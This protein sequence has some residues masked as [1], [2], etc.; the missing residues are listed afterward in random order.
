MLKGKIFGYIDNN[1]KWIYNY[2]MKLEIK[3]FSLNYFGHSDSLHSINHTFYEGLNVVF[4]VEGSGKTSLLK[5]IAGVNYHHDG[6]VLFEDKPVTLGKECDIS[7]V[8]DDLGFFEKRSL[9]YNLMYP[10]IIR[11]KP[12]VEAMEIIKKWLDEF[13]IP[14]ILLESKVFRLAP[15]F[16]VSAGLIRGFYRESKIIILDNP[17]ASLYQYDRTKL[18]LFLAKYLKQTNS[19]VIYATDSV[20]EVN[21]LNSPTLVLS[22][23]YVAE[24][25]IPSEFIENPKCLATSELLIPYFNKF[26]VKL[27]S[28]GFNLFGKFF[29][30]DLTGTLAESFV[31]KEVVVGFKPDCVI[32]GNIPAVSPLTLN[33]AKREI[34]LLKIE[35]KEV[36]S[37]KLINKIGLDTKKILLFDPLTERVVYQ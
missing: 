24:S 36:Y 11:K 17:L 27:E 32:S 9:K 2:H 28:N 16:K 3:D 14:E 30:L 7:F 23:G 25:G 20:E 4:G 37:D 15:N 8:F 26:D 31:G 12:K 33:T 10:F 34:Y 18:F 21:L 6:E 1:R 13:E 29:E 5:A 35:G 19:I 22:Y